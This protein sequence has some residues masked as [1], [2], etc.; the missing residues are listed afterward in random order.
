MHEQQAA[1]PRPSAGRSVFDG[2][3][4]ERTDAARAEL[5]RRRLAAGSVVIAEGDTV[6]E[7]YVVEAGV[8]DVFVAD[9]AGEEHRVGSVHAGGTLGEMSLFTG[10]PATGTV[11]AAT[12]LQLIVIGA[13][14]FERIATEYPVVYRNLGAILSERL[15]R[16]NRLAARQAPGHVVHL[17]DV[18]GPPLLAWALASSVAW[19]TRGRT[20]LLVVGER[21]PE[22]LTSLL[23]EEPAGAVVRR[24]GAHLATCDPETMAGT[25]HALSGSDYDVV[26]VLA[27]GAEHRLPNVGELDLGALVG[28]PPLSD[29]ELE[30]LR[31]GLLP[32]R[33]GAGREL[34][35][36]ARTLCGL[37]VG[38][39]LGA[40]SVR[41][42]AHWGVLRA[43][44]KLGLEADFVA[45]TSIGATVGAMYAQGRGI[46]AG[47]DTLVR[48]GP[49]L[50]RY[51]IPRKGLLSN[52]GVSKF[53][54]SELGELRI[55]DLPIPLALVAADILTQQEVVFR[56]GLLWQAV[57]ASLSIPGVYPA[58]WIGEHLVVDGGVLNPVPVSV[59]AQ[60]GADVVLAVR[61]VGEC[62]P[63]AEVEAVIAKG[64]PPS[65]I[66][67]IMRSIELMQGRIGSDVASARTITITPGLVDLPSNKLKS[68]GEGPRFVDVGE[69]A[70]EK[71]L[72]RIEAALP[73]IR[74]E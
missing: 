58:L 59:A 34:G 49:H 31:R 16:T 2:V 60:M 37:R 23:G 46:D 62:A 67:V 52:R 40:G 13:D 47:I 42:F 10:Q 11:R 69:T 74:P 41:G 17:R 50:V 32:N 29:L 21:P 61:L 65:A 48:S 72:P 45:G 56:R 24:E 51:G 70:V 73:W 54:H 53:I 35:K 6:H 44:E 30:S 9:A 12:E 28:L 14:E 19:H 33:T 27:R 1:V 3:P 55:E 4:A 15:A 7:F 57:V 43:L 25:V 8:A 38:I 63:H 18:G 39:A 36:V 20:L 26:L 22:E 71:A 64:T 5:P 68:F 66:G